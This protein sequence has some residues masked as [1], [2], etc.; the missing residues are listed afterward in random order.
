[1]KLL[2]KTQNDCGHKYVVPQQIASTKVGP[3]N[4]CGSL[5]A[6]MFR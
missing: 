1:M 2:W 6:K 3:E 4:L 5:F